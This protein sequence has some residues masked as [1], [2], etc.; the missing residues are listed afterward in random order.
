MG[1][2]KKTLAAV[3][4]RGVETPLQTGPEVSDTKSE[5]KYGEVY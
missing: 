2:P 3:N 5:S 1:D 4:D